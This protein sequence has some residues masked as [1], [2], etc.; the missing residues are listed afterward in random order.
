MS[1]DA[2]KQSS[3]TQSILR[4]KLK[5]VRDL[6]DDPD[7]QEMLPNLDEVLQAFLDGVPFEAPILKPKTFAQLLSLANPIQALFNQLASEVP[8]CNLLDQIEQACFLEPEKLVIAR[9]LIEA[10]WVNEVA[11]KPFRPRA[12]W[13]YLPVEEAIEGYR[14]LFGS[15]LRADTTLKLAGQARARRD[16]EGIA[17]W[18]KLSTFSKLFGVEGNPLLTTDEG[19][20]A[21]ARV[22]EM[23]IPEVGKAFVAAG[24]GGFKN[25]R[26][27]NLTANHIILIPAGIV[28]WEKLEQLTDDDFCFSPAG[29]NTG[30]AYAGYS[31]RRGRIG[32]VLASDQFPQ[33]CLMT[34]GTLAT[35]PERMS[36][37][38]HLGMD[39]P[40]NA[41]SRDTVGR[42]TRSVVWGFS[43][44]GLRFAGRSADDADR[45]IGSTAGFLS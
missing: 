25:W 15:S 24:L 20:A 19:R 30:S 44:D 21:Y 26:Q 7:R 34:G 36:K 28:A 14:K 38:E 27:D 16:S 41:Y 8:F 9:P 29:A 4:E 3:V 13:R 11:A 5:R 39:C 40:G 2:T 12:N 18:L 43:C 32:I 6:V 1:N 45:D 31:V 35:Q 17:I 33:D 22:V 10:L 42:F 23:V 37:Y